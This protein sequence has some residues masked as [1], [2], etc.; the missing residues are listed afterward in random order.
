MGRKKTQKINRR[1]LIRPLISQNKKKPWKRQDQK[2][3]DMGVVLTFE[4]CF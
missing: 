3:Q 1:T 2:K 4:C